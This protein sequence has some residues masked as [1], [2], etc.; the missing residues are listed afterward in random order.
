[1]GIFGAHLGVDLLG[2][3]MVIALLNGG[4]DKLALRG[5]PVTQIP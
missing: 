3:Y 4:E 1:V 2:A 5:K